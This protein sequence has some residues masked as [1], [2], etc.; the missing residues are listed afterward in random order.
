MTQKEIDLII[1]CINGL[2]VELYNLLRDLICIKSYSS[3]EKE[4]VEFIINQMNHKQFDESFIDKFGNAIGRVG[5]GPVKILYDAHVDTVDVTESEKWIHPPFE[6]K[7]ENGKIELK[8]WK[9]K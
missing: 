9:S 8:I 7:I 3:D 6:G 2:H 1:D 5:D 4:I